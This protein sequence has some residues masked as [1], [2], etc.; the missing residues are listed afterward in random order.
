MNPEESIGDGVLLAAPHQQLQI[1][2][3]PLPIHQRFG[4]A[5][6]EKQSVVATGQPQLKPLLS[7]VEGDG[8]RQVEGVLDPGAV[9]G[10]VENKPIALQNHRTP[11]QI[12]G[13]AA[14]A[15]IAE[16]KG[17]AE[18]GPAPAKAVTPLN[19]EPAPQATGHGRQQGDQRER[20]GAD[21]EVAIALGQ[22]PLKT[23]NDRLL[24]EG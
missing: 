12:E 14:K 1:E 10:E 24:G 9:Q 18:L 22:G 2:T 20:Q 7:R 15:G 17:Q 11:L 3:P 16:P 13:R 23:D 5:G 6:E 8:S 21:A 19:L 4:Q